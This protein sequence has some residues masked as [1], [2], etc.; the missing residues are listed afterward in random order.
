MPL[1][2]ASNRPVLAPAALGLQRQCSTPLLKL[3]S[4]PRRARRAVAVNSV[5]L[6][7]VENSINDT[8]DKTV[9]AYDVTKQVVTDIS[10]KASPAVSALVKFMEAN[11]PAVQKGIARKIMIGSSNLL[12]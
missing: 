2:V 6:D 11:A 5:S 7:S 10:E 8:I 3:S 4:G 9:A 1:S 12:Q